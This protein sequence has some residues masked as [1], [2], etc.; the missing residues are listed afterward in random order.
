MNNKMWSFKIYSENYTSKAFLLFELNNKAY[1]FNLTVY[2][3]DCDGFDN[4][5]NLYYFFYEEINKY[6]YKKSYI[7]YVNCFEK[8]ANNI[9]SGKKLKLFDIDINK[10]LLEEN[11]ENTETVKKMFLEINEYILR[12]IIKYYNL[13]TSFLKDYNSID[14]YDDEIEKEKYMYDDNNYE[15]EQLNYMF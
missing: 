13:K 1:S 6:G 15:V 11:I 9:N 8:L 4:Q 2:T 7:E 3:P 10:E 14:D 5:L 12:K